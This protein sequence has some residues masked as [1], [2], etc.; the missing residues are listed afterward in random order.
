MCTSCRH[1]HTYIAEVSNDMFASIPEVGLHHPPLACGV[2]ASAPHKLTPSG[3]NGDL[4]FVADLMYSIFAPVVREAARRRSSNPSL[5]N[6]HGAPLKW[7][8]L[9]TFVMRR[10]IHT[11]H[12]HVSINVMKESARERERGG[13]RERI[14]PLGVAPAL[15]YRGRLRYRQQCLLALTTYQKRV[16]SGWEGGQDCHAHGREEEVSRRRSHGWVP[17]DVITMSH[18]NLQPHISIKWQATNSRG[19]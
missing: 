12:T 10:V 14:V 16:R 1:V 5:P 3:T 18:W 19:Q 13:G 11:V 4:A 17:N 7:W 2:D 6:P 8:Y 15:P 9:E